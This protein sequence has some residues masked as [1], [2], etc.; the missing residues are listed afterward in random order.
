MKYQE[1][2][3]ASPPPTQDYYEPAPHPSGN[4]IIT[5]TMLERISCEKVMRIK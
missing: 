2:G 1:S 5:H 4:V 3:E